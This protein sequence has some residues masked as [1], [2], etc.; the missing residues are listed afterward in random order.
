VI[1]GICLS[2]VD[3]RLSIGVGVGV[4]VGVGEPRVT[5]WSF[6]K[7]VGRGLVVNERWKEERKCLVMINRKLIDDRLLR[8]NHDGVLVLRDE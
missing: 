4:G 3:C 1:D 2:I 7:G 5:C 6:L 8:F